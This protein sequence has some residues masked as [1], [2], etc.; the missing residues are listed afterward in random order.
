MNAAHPP[1]ARRADRK[2]LGMEQYVNLAG[3]LTLAYLLLMSGVDKATDFGHLTYALDTAP[4]ADLTVGAVM[5]IELGGGVLLLLGWHT[6]QMAIALA[7]VSA[8]SAWLFDSTLGWLVT[9]ALLLLAVHGSCA[10]SLDR[11]FKRT[12][13]T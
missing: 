2:A 3:R 11:R 5:A 9:A 10:F 7:V 12:G 4:W 8:V 1:H 6:R 13:C